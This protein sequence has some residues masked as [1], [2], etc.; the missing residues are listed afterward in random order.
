MRIQR[1]HRV[2]VYVGYANGSKSCTPPKKEHDTL[3]IFISYIDVYHHF[4][5]FPPFK[6][7]FVVYPQGPHRYPINPCGRWPVSRRGDARDQFQPGAETVVLQ[8]HRV[9]RNDPDQPGQ[10]LHSLGFHLIFLGLS[11]IWYSLRWDPLMKQAS[12]SFWSR[13]DVS[14]CRACLMDY[15]LTPLWKAALKQLKPETTLRILNTAEVS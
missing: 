6:L 3:Y 11:L 1:N 15:E 14:W 10:W 5:S 9:T 13:V 7:K 8:Q 2:I 12:F 4:P